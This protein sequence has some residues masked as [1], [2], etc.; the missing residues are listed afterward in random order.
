MSFR[1]DTDCNHNANSLYGMAWTL[2]QPQLSADSQSGEHERHSLIAWAAAQ[3]T[4]LRSV[5]CDQLERLVHWK[6][7]S[8]TLTS[9]FFH[10]SSVRAAGGYLVTQTLASVLRPAQLTHHPLPRCIVFHSARTRKGSALDRGTSPCPYRWEKCLCLDWISFQR[11]E[12]ELLLTRPHAMVFRL[13]GEIL[14]NA[15]YPSRYKV[16][17]SWA[18]INCDS[19]G[20]LFE[21][22]SAFQ[23]Q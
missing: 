6:V 5:T 20:S 8:V 16:A 21:I 23:I 9:F 7:N 12:F 18:K 3:E 1:F 4:L 17:L 14:F 22:N 15:I 13:M 10:F 11:S 19:L 2:L